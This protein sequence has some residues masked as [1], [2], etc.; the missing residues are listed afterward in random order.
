MRPGGSDEYLRP[1][2]W[3]A[4]CR[5]FGPEPPLGSGGQSAPMHSAPTKPTRMNVQL[6]ANKAN[7]RTHRNRRERS[8][9]ADH[10]FRRDAQRGR[11]T[12]AKDGRRNEANPI[13]ELIQ[14]VAERSQRGW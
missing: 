2:V 12:E 3:A 10:A 14:L 11:R 4:D 8:Q 9:S 6:G 13:P 7:R 5:R 1:M